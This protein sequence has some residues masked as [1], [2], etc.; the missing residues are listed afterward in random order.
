MSVHLAFLKPKQPN[1]TALSGAILSKPL[2]PKAGLCPLQSLVTL[3][4]LLPWQP[5]LT[6]AT[7]SQSWLLR[8]FSEADAWLL[9]WMYW[10]TVSGLDRGDLQQQNAPLSYQRS[11]ATIQGLDME[12]TIFSPPSAHLSRG[13]GFKSHDRRKFFRHKIQCRDDTHA[14]ADFPISLPSNTTCPLLPKFFINAL[15]SSWIIKQVV[16]TYIVT[17]WLSYLPV[18]SHTHK[19]HLGNFLVHACFVGIKIPTTSICNCS[20]SSALIILR[21]FDVLGR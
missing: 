15:P 4:P 21:S 7:L 9:W 2:G 16:D 6:R 5:N 19:A 20:V 11:V 17:Y 18:L 1:L 3:R 10:G 12:K 13:R 14:Q 8:A